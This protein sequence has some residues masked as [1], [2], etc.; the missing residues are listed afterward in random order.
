MV[1]ALED[2]RTTNNENRVTVIMIA[3]IITKLS[4]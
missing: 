3:T 1:T 4:V 2:V